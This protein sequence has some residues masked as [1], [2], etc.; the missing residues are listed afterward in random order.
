M[1][2][3]ASYNNVINSKYHLVAISGNRGRDANFIGDVYP[4]L[5]PK[6]E[7]WKIWHENIGKISE[8]ENNQYYI[9]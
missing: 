7:F 8:M 6:K 2:C 4:K 3:T 1:I 5:A 9:C